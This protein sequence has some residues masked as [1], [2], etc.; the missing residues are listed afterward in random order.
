MCVTKTTKCS[1]NFLSVHTIAT[2]HTNGDLKAFLDKVNGKCKPNLTAIAYHSMPSG[3]GWKG[4]VA[5]QSTTV[6]CLLLRPCSVHPCLDTTEEAIIAGR[7]V[8][9]TSYEKPDCPTLPQQLFSTASNSPLLNASPIS[10]PH[11]MLS[12]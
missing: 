8:T 1:K 3:T 4:G 6:N 12:S 9:S 2:A 7:S 11:S 10:L 5:E